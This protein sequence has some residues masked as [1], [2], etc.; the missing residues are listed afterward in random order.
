LTIVAQTRPFVIG[1][2]CHART[3]TYAIIEASSKRQV[4]CEQF[5]TTSAGISRTPAWVGRRTDGDVA[6]LWA[7]EGIGSYGARLARAVTD[8]G[9]DVIVSARAFASAVRA[10]DTPPLLVLLNSCNSAAQIDQLVDDVA[11]FAIGMADEINDGDAVTYAAQFYAAVANGHSIQS[12][13]FSAQ[14]ALALGGLEG[15]ELPTL[16]W[17]ADVDPS[18]T[19]L[20]KP[21]EKL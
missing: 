14:A 4:A 9:Y 10:T 21:A 20:V 17:A 2:D 5:P 18:I 6:C 12:S 13:H 15:A 11:P 19:V 16:A 3:H 1:V 8:A 7:V